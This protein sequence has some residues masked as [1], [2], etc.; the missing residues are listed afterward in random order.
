MCSVILLQDLWIQEYSK[1]RLDETIIV[2]RQQQLD[3]PQV[4]RTTGTQLGHNAEDMRTENM[5]TAQSHQ[6]HKFCPVTDNTTRVCAPDEELNAP[7]NQIVNNMVGGHQSDITSLSTL[8]DEIYYVIR[9]KKQHLYESE[10]HSIDKLIV[11]LDFFKHEFINHPTN[12]NDGFPFLILQKYL[13][14]LK[15]GNNVCDTYA[16]SFSIPYKLNIAMCI[17]CEWLGDQFLALSDAIFKN[18]G[19]FKEQHLDCIDNLPPPHVIICDLFPRCMQILLKH[20]LKTDKQIAS[21]SSAT[22]T[23]TPSKRH[24]GDESSGV[25][26]CRDNDA[27]IQFILEFTSG[28]LISGVAHVVYSR[29]VNM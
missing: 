25:L 2:S 3:I 6:I 14:L 16:N 20:W 11:M 27:L 4:C 12:E 23:S 21:K 8:L 13:D 29:L 19:I 5:R 26:E 15:G 7:P 17:I 22:C 24:C 18:V 9:L 10:Q 1:N 28:A